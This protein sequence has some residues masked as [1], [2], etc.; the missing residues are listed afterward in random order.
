MVERAQ[1]FEPG[2]R[3]RF[4]R[5][6]SLAWLFPALALLLPSLSAAQSG[7]YRAP[8][9]V[10]ARWS[11]NPHHALIWNGEP[12]VPFGARIGAS[13]LEIRAAK[14]AGLQDV[15]VD[16][17]PHPELLRATVSLLE[18][19]EMRYLIA[20]SGVPSASSGILVEPQSN[21]IAG[22]TE[23]RTL[24]FRIPGAEEAL[25]VLAVRRDG[26]VQ[27]VQRV[28]ARE[29]QFA[30]EVAPPNELEHVAMIY[31]VTS[32]HARLGIGE[33]FD[34]HRD[35]LLAA[36]G[37]A[38]F[39]KGLRGFVNPLGAIPQPPGARSF[40]PTGKVFQFEFSAYL[41]KLYRSPET[42]MRS[43]GMAAAEARDF[44][45]LAR[46]VPLWN[47]SRGVESLWDPRNDKLYPVEMRRSTIWRDL[48]AALAAAETRRTERL[49][50]SL[51]RIADVPVLQE[52]SGWSPIYEGAPNGLD[53]LATRTS[54][55][56]P[57]L[58][59]DTAARAASSLMRWSRGGWFLATS[60][61]MGSV[62]DAAS[63]LGPV[64]DDLAS[65]G[66]RGAFLQSAGRPLLS[67]LAQAAPSRSPASL[68]SHS[69]RPIFF[70]ESATNPATAMRLPAGA[71]WLPAPSSGNRVD[72]G[73]GFH[74]YR[75]ED[76]A[77]SRF[78]LWSRSGRARVK[79]LLNAPKDALFQTVD[80]SDPNPRAGRDSVEVQ[81]TELP[82][83][84][85]GVGELP[86]PE[87][88]LTELVARFEAM[89]AE[90]DSRNVDTTEERFLFRDYLSGLTR[91]PGGNY[92]SLLAVSRRLASKLARYLWI[93]AE[94]TRNSSFSEIVSTPGLSGDNAIAL[95]T[96]LVTSDGDYFCEYQVQPRSEQEVECWIAARIP[97]SERPLVR[98]EIG[99]QVLRIQG[100][101]VS[102]YGPGYAWFP[103]G[104]TRMAR[105]QTT[106]TLR[107][108]ASEGADL[109]V[110]A[111]LFYPGAFKPEGVRLP[112]PVAFRP[113]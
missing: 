38:G 85:S 2:A 79:L 31:P 27:N 48:N 65:L 18:R 69:P 88:S 16:C 89:I 11:I 56:S 74:A 72:L 67:A 80:G 86:I 70:P 22:L 61:D 82:L 58:L 62:P 17:P 77:G 101:P 32:S 106:V 14:A 36:L 47:G 50:A 95:R 75:I 63:Q 8:G 108:A 78:V 91:N 76:A 98:I 68:A 84:I 103:L 19:E 59:A 40:L 90:A 113:G 45:Q 96:Q 100:D 26:Y 109:A 107:V 87:A 20:I 81:I 7:H 12:Y 35:A 92:S 83:I 93:E 42:C 43:W 23:K 111:I 112:D 1:Q 21:R 25:V 3:R 105:E 39:G 51:K 6:G 10:E 33:D 97:P 37:Q 5:A 28:R 34:H 52:W 29:G 99:G 44:D 4:G 110:D 102:G 57:S 104:K 55:A 60:V 49:I 64:L 66:V 73:S 94:A 13:E 46:L 24:R 9:G 53:G 41:S 30:V 15:V 54:G 71:W